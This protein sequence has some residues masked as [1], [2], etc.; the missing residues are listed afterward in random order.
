MQWPSR[1]AKS[2]DTTFHN[3]AEDVPTLLLGGQMERAS[4]QVS[5]ISR[6]PNGPGLQDNSR[7]N[8]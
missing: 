4:P 8:G 6:S 7:E 1:L 2:P 3:T 5:E